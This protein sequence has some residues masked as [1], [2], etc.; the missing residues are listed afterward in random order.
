LA[1][2]LE[3]IGISK[4]FPGVIA[5]DG[6][7]FDLQAGEIHTLL[8]ENGAGK[9]TLMNIAYGLLR[10]DGGEIWAGGQNVH[11]RSPLD[12]LAH[13]LGMV[14][15]HFMLVPTLS[16]TE[17]IVL[18]HELTHGPFLAQRTAVKHIERLSADFG[19]EVSPQ[20]RVSE[21]SVGEQQ[22]VEILKALYHGADILIMDEPTAAITPPETE[23]LFSTLRS[24]RTHGKSVIFISH[25]LREVMAIS[26]R[27][28]V[29]R[30]G[31]RV[32]CVRAAETDEQQL[33]MMMVGREV[34]LTVSRREAAPEGAVVAALDGVSVKGRGEKPALA[35]IDLR[36]EAGEIL[37]VAGVDGNGQSELAEVL[38]GLRSPDGGQMTLQGRI[39]KGGNP[40]DQAAKGVWYVPA[41]RRARGA[42]V[43]LPIAANAV[44]KSRRWSPFSHRGVLDHAQIRL[45]AERL[46]REYDVRC[47]SVMA[48]AGTL[49]GGNLQKLILARETAYQPKLLIAEHPTRGLDIG[50][51]DYVRRQ[52]IRQAD[53]GAAVVLISGDLDEIMALSDRI[54][55]M[56]EGAVVYCCK[57]DDVELERLGLAM[58][59]LRLSQEAPSGR[60]AAP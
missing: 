38:A 3:L 50:A 24:M 57:R 55:V 19:L 21:L 6:V 29:L 18:G 40:G 46:T 52:L 47:P 12:A 48:P 22:R 58:A 44:L 35:S 10:P 37:G 31:R 45:F 2:V 30:R 14:H 17:N 4:R 27:I 7:D 23:A 25:K 32:G 51:T 56:Y 15:Q 49:S 9:T 33:A 39:V 53:G 11:F 5:N 16:V 26:D 59:G 8:G 13:G 34:V 36:L 42:V 54:I 41:D 20:R 1:A 28:T 60:E 43:E